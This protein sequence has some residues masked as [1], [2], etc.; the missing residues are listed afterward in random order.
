MAFKM[1]YDA[2]NKKA[3][4]TLAPR[5]KVLAQKFYDFCVKNGIQ[6]LIT[7][8]RRTIEKQREYVASGASKTLKSYHLVGQALDFVPVVGDDINYNLYRKKPFN[9]AVLYAKKLGFKWGG[10]W[11][12]DS[13]H[14]E[15]HYKGYGTDEKAVLPAMPTKPKPKPAP[16]KAPVRNYLKEGDKGTKVGELQ[17][18]LVKAGYRIKVDKDFGDKTDNAVRAFQK[19]HKLKV[20]GLAGVSTIAKLKAV[21]K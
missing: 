12:W 2:R 8:G 3:I 21:T 4:A 7:E 9:D 5:T 16:K 11:G 14:L 15:Y 20:D 6:I 10:D 13:P 19:K 1:T 17:A 18:L